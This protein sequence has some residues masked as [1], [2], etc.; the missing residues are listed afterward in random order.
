MT[1]PEYDDAR[2]ELVAALAEWIRLAVV[3]AVA[4]GKSRWDAG[5]AAMKPLDRA[6]AAM[7][8]ARTHAEVNM[9]S[10]SEMSAEMVAAVERAMKEDV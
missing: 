7:A 5:D 2:H 1:T 8:R 6:L 3:Q 4:E 9:R 10:P